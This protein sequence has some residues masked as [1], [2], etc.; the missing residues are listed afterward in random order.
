MRINT[1]KLAA[2]TALPDEKMWAQ[3]REIASGHGI[4]LPEKCPD[5]KTM[6][7]I[8]SAASGGAKINLAEAI[9]VINRYKKGE[10]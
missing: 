7:D 5:S 3:I 8:R 1:E 6:S 10:S 2:L 9:R 4:S